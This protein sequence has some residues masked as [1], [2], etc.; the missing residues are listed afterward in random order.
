MK[1]VMLYMPVYKNEKNGT[2]YAM[3]R[4]KDWMGNN[5]Q[6]CQRGFA[7]KR[8]AQDWES[9]FRLQKRADIDM[10]MESFC[11]MYER[12][13][14]PKLK[15]NTWLSKENVIQTKIL[16]YL[17]KRKV[18]EITPK[19]VVDWQNRMRL[20][21]T[22]DGKLLSPTY[23]KT[24]HAQLSA[25]FNHAVRYYNLTRNPAIQAG[26]MG[27]EESKEMLFWTEEEYRKFAVEMMDKPLSYYAFEL[28]Y[29]CGIR[30]GELLALTAEDFDFE[31][32]TLRIN[33][34]YQ[35]LRRRDV[36]TSPKTRQS[37]RIIRIPD[38]LTDEMKDFIKMYY[39]LTPKDRLFPV[40][41]RYL[42]H[43]M[44][45]G[46]KASGVK[47]IRIHDLRHSHVSLLIDM[48]F[49]PLAIGKRVGHTSTKITERYSHLFPS[50]QDDMADQLNELRNEAIKKD[51]EEENG[52]V[53]KK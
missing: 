27:E 50:V 52:N 4:Y 14:R 2:W 41:K 30:E 28:L 12:D 51:D 3:V 45:R 34:S 26:S 9:Q 1:G 23:L 35:R 44:E 36:I 39:S 7:T 20:L 18:A 37:N 16:P 32:K 25:I 24:I 22:K 43:E 40:T 17:G 38:F 49:S 47:K 31:A 6:K 21:K 33:K 42:Q 10:T 48:G 11:E 53:R 29:W 19:D 13:V 5:K 46:C 15:A 8:E